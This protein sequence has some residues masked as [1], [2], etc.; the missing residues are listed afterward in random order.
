MP[1]QRTATVARICEHCG[2]TFK[3]WSA[4]IRRGGGKYCGASCYHVA[5][6]TPIKQRFWH[7][8]K[9]APDEND[10]WGWSGSLN[11]GYPQ[12]HGAPG[13]TPGG[14]VL[15]FGHRISWEIHYGPIPDGLWVLHRCDVRSCTNPRHLF[16][17]THNDNVAD[18]VAKRRQPV[19]ETHYLTKLT[20]ADICSI[21]ER[22]A[23][24]K[25]RQKDLA[26][27][28]GISAGHISSILAGNV[29]RTR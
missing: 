23:T 3:T 8:A 26:T 6:T 10:C 17:G 14:R 5:R 25:F 15:M 2:L 27:E 24:G 1:K 9:P 11:H 12:L 13:T 28:Y 7:F 29:R 18:K 16:L 4:E 19:G 22:Y 21:R 20:W